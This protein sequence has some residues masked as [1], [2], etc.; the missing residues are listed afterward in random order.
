MQTGGFLHL[1]E[2]NA[3]EDGQINFYQMKKKIELKT[4]NWM[5]EWKGNRM[6]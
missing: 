4:V 3:V 1:R 6:F 5:R 2:V